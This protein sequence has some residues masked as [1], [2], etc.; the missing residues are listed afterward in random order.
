VTVPER[1]AL[2]VVGGSFALLGTDSALES[3]DGLELVW[4]AVAVIG[5]AILFV[6][7]RGTPS[8]LRG[9][10]RLLRLKPLE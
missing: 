10:G 5:L 3:R 6:S 2:A 8:S 9:V 1:V 7:T 4:L